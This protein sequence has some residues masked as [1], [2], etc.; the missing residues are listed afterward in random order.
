MIEGETEVQKGGEVTSSPCCDS[1]KCDASPQAG[2]SAEGA[3]PSAPVP[4]CPICFSAYDG[5]FRAPLR[6]PL[7]GHTFC[8]VCLSRMSLFP[9][10]PQ[11]FQC[12]L[13]RT[14]VPL[15]PGGAP[16]LPP[17]AELLSRLPQDQSSTLKR[18]W[19]EGPVLCHW[20][21]PEGGGAPAEGVVRLPLIGAPP[22]AGGGAGGGEGQPVAM[23]TV[24]SRRRL[25]SCR[26]IRGLAMIST[27]L[28]VIIFFAIF[29]PVYF[30]R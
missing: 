27:L 15:P 16:C 12:P 23:V 29:L 11:G 30:Q 10:R 18:V 13:C 5:A 9:S 25:D 7:C 21:G 1:P 22:A 17:N 2:H 3:P 4:E 28:L 8:L 19:L 20:T 14:P 26:N 6:L 24:L